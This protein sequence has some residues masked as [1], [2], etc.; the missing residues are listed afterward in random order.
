LLRGKNSIVYNKDNVNGHN[1]KRDKA[2]HLPTLFIRGKIGN[3]L[4]FLYGSCRKLHGKGEDCLAIADELI[5]DSV[6]DLDKRPCTLFLSGDQ[7]YADDV[8]DPLIQYLAQFG[9]KLLLGWEE[10]IIGI[11]RKLTELR[12]GQRQQIVNEYAKFTSENTGN[13]LLSFGEFAACI[14]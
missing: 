10:Q 3:P 11:D 5:S 12:I 2:I 9:V 4:N 8:A 7:I 14:L 13:H 1:G 6:N